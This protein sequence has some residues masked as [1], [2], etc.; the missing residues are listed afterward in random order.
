[1]AKPGLSPELTSE[2]VSFT[3]LCST[4]TRFETRGGAPLHLL[5]GG[6]LSGGSP[7]DEARLAPTNAPDCLA[8]G[9]ASSVRLC[10]PCPRVE[11]ALGQPHAVSSGCGQGC[12]AGSVPPE[13]WVGVAG[14]RVEGKVLQQDKL[15][16]EQALRVQQG[17]TPQGNSYGLR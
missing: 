15:S 3:R 14:W 10:K 13:G 6:G 11:Q 1:M 9:L 7:L 12:P 8:K 5:P 17:H 2:P 16:P 4:E